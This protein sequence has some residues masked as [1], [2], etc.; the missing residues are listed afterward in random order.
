MDGVG[1][2][3][4]LRPIPLRLALNLE[5]TEDVQRFYPMDGS[6]YGPT[7]HYLDINTSFCTF[8]ADGLDPTRLPVTVMT[9]LQTLTLNLGWSHFN[10]VSPAWLAF[11][12]WLAALTPNGCGVL[13]LNLMGCTN[14]HWPC[15]VDFVETVAQKGWLETFNVNLSYAHWNLS[16]DRRHVTAMLHAV[17]R[18]STVSCVTLQFH[19][20][21]HSVGNGLA[22]ILETV[23]GPHC[24]RAP[25]RKVTIDLSF[26]GLTNPGMLALVRCIHGMP[27]SV[28]FLDIGLHGNR[29]QC[30]PLRR[31]ILA[32]SH[33]PR[34]RHLTLNLEHSALSTRCSHAFRMLGDTEFSPSA[35]ES[36]HL[37]LSHNMSD[38]LFTSTANVLA[39][40][41][42][43]KKLK[44]RLA[45]HVPSIAFCSPSQ[46]PY[47]CL[48]GDRD[49]EALCHRGGTAFM[50][51]CMDLWMH[52]IGCGPA[53]GVLLGQWLCRVDD[54]R[55]E[56]SNNCL[57]TT[58]V[59]ML[60]DGLVQ[61]SMKHLWLRLSSNGIGDAVSG[62]WSMAHSRCHH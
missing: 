46:T 9:N 41:P 62:R 38:F 37:L 31:L 13:N 57:E 36:V 47:P 48:I 27:T 17:L 44:L 39:G 60:M 5:T 56:L 52:N 6:S 54:L 33:R 24:V 32:I 12:Q 61:G 10:A 20:G 8:A 34:L 29:V 11:F 23:F 59:R 35:I 42:L 21:R 43:L 30:G 45:R 28:S 2:L 22:K 3:T 7:V 1:Q 25:L 58:G 50:P 16:V 4:P 26:T 19:S 51:A 15:V 49:V 14:V 55:L 53:S 18:S 40:N